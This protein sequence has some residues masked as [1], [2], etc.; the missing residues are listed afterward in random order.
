[1]KRL[2]SLI[3]RDQKLIDQAGATLSGDESI[4]NAIDEKLRAFESSGESDA[5]DLNERFETF[6]KQ[7]RDGEVDDADFLLE[8]K[9]HVAMVI[10]KLKN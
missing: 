9:N 1:M 3:E 8:M 4:E 5:D 7:A 6:C 2:T 10:K